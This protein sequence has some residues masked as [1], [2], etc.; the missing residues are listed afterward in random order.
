INCESI[1]GHCQGD[2]SEYPTG[3]TLALRPRWQALAYV[4]D[5]FLILSADEQ[6]QEVAA[7]VPKR[8]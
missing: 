4:N 1:R 6:P 3:L 2:C 8:P 7:D 5:R